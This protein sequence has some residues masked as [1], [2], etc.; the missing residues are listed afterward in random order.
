MLIAWRGTTVRFLLVGPLERESQL[1]AAE[2]FDDRPASD[3]TASSSGHQDALVGH[4][5][6]PGST[7]MRSR[8]DWDVG[9]FRQKTEW[10]RPPT[11][12]VFE[13]DA[14]R[15][16]TVV[17]QDVRLVRAYSDIVLAVAV[18]DVPL[19]V[20]A[21]DRDTAIRHLELLLTGALV[22]CLQF[23]TSSTIQLPLQLRWVSRTLLMDPDEDL[24]D[25]RFLDE[26]MGSGLPET[27]GFVTAPGAVRTGSFSAGWGNNVYRGNADAGDP[28]FL[29]TVEGLVDAQAIWTVIADLDTALRD[30]VTDREQPI[31]HD[32]EELE[33]LKERH[34]VLRTGL[35]EYS[36]RMQGLR[37][38]VA[39][40]LLTRW[41]QAERLR[42][43]REAFNDMGELLA[44]SVNRSKEVYQTLVERLLAVIG[45]VALADV[46]L[47]VVQLA[48]AGGIDDV[49]GT[50]T[51]RVAPRILDSVRATPSDD[52]LLVTLLIF[53]GT[54]AVL[55][56]VL[57]V[58]KQP[59]KTSPKLQ[60]PRR[61]LR[62]GAQR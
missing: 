47:G 17:A 23:H 29:Q 41:G 26:W 5:G 50:R 52:L 1:Q 25:D 40:E 15:Q 57:H 4:A 8:H 39:G 3:T 49:P 54:A 20:V 38:A 36:A 9:G 6:D 60:R 2:M 62:S 16:L 19:D 55:F 43:I 11:A 34:M 61:R 33:A 51:P 24:G 13:S 32:L 53:L 14:D 21:D 30:L 28:A 35:V 46:V 56:A 37:A 10:R 27:D 59:R 22:R 58:L 31:S 44:T 45:V 48:F 42:E 18:V 7:K 12:L